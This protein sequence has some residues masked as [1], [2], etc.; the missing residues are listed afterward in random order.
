MKQ[1]SICFIFLIF[2]LNSCNKETDEYR[3]SGAETVYIRGYQHRNDIG[4]TMG[5]I[6]NPDIRLRYPTDNSGIPD[7]SLISFPNPGMTNIE[8]QLFAHGY[9]GEVRVWIIPASFTGQGSMTTSFLEP[10]LVTS[11]EKPLVDDVFQFHAPE[12]IFHISELPEGYYR[13]YVKA[14]GN[15]VWD[16]IVFSKVEQNYP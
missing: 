9:T 8:V 14:G 12:I 16:N 7:L 10:L 3:A 2:L 6:G 5:D 1:I 15:L 4:M 13:I 11:H